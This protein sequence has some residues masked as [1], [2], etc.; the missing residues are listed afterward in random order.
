MF[1]SELVQHELW[2]KAPYWL[3]LPS[4]QWP[5]QT[6]TPLSH[7]LPEE[8]RDLCL[9]TV[10]NISTPIIPLERYSSFT[11]LKRVTAW[12]LRFIHNC[13]GKKQD[14]PTSTHLSTAE[15]MNAEI[16][17]TSLAQGQAFPDKIEALRNNKSISTSSCLFSLHP[18]V[19]SSG[20]LRVGGRRQ[21]TQL[22]YSIIHPIILPGKHPITSLLISS[23]LRRLMHVGPT[24]L[25]AS[26]N[27]RYYITWCRRIVHSITHDCIIC[28]HTTAKPK[29]QLLGQLPAERITPDYVF[30]H[31]GLNYAGPFTIKYGSNRKPT[32]VKAYVCVFV[33]LSIKAIHLEIASDLTTDAFIAVLRRFIARRGKPSIIWS[34][35]G[36]NFVGAVG[37]LNEFITFYQ[38]Q[39]TQGLISDFCTM[40][41]FIPEHTP[42]FGGLWEAAVKSMKSHLKR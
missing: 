42:H 3:K 18:F 5:A 33:S 20:L 29:P 11:Q 1:P 22:S 28:R 9:H 24:L 35:H 8:E 12:I 15:L 4:G 23:E 40:Q 27:R 25:T 38:N 2:W 26:L 6:C 14:Q 30:N 7:L 37:Q 39:K 31:V 19:D 21:N 32:L 17:W 13:H 36:T 16:Y 34:N 41:K 10:I